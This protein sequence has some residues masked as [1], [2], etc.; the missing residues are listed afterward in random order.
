MRAH[1]TCPRLN[2]KVGKDTPIP[3]LRA[4][5]HT[6]SFLGNLK[7]KKKCGRPLVGTL[8]T[9]SSIFTGRV[10]KEC[11]FGGGGRVAVGVRV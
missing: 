8:E 5:T 2:R 9:A 10:W 3:N 11:V 1:C 4:R 7:K 6:G